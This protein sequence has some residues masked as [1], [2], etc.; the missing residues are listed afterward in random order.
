MN[1]LDLKT[2]RDLGIQ[3]VSLDKIVG[4]S[5]RYR[6]FDLSFRPLRADLRERWINIAQLSGSNHSLPPVRLYM[7]GQVYFVEDGNHRISVA[8]SRDQ[9]S[10]KALVIEFDPS[11]LTPNLECKRLGY[12]A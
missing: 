11:P 9:Q 6:D 7:I 8:R 12:K 10:I 1:H 2:A 3:D 4:S 5:G